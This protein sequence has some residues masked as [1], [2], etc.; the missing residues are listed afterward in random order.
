MI[1]RR[2]AVFVLLTASVCLSTS[3]DAQTVLSLEAGFAKSLQATELPGSWSG[4]F[5]YGRPWHA[6]E[7]GIELGYADLGTNHGA[8]ASTPAP[9]A[10]AGTSG[11]TAWHGGPV[12]AL[13]LNQSRPRPTVYLG[14][15]FY[16]VELLID[17]TFYDASGA[18]LSGFTVNTRR[19][20]LGPSAAFTVLPAGSTR[21]TALSLSLRLDVPVTFQSGGNGAKVHEGPMLNP[22]VTL[23]AGVRWRVKGS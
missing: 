2:Q 4:V 14:F 1:A 18:P 5:R 16:R 6:R 11:Q 7:W 15:Q 13:P 3:L 12:V 22:W 9:G 19:Y 23:L 8:P 21:G 10:V 17:S 20:G